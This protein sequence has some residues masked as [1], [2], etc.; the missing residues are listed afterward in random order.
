MST[1]SM[2]ELVL[3]TEG[4]W[5]FLFLSGFSVAWT[6]LSS[7][8]PKRRRPKIRQYPNC[9]EKAKPAWAFP[10]AH[11]IH[12]TMSQ[13]VAR[14][15][16]M[17][18]QEKERAQVQGTGSVGIPG[19][20]SRL[21]ESPWVWCHQNWEIQSPFCNL[22]TLP[23]S[24]HL[25]LALPITSRGQAPKHTTSGNCLT[26]GQNWNILHILTLQQK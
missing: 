14:P 4:R 24:R 11:H 26:C 12:K 20:R 19:H 22:Q 15:S 13:E 9:F 23:S 8:L 10:H 17:W 7:L 21:S 25:T 6:S 3:R 1:H 5:V 2:K 16:R 18:V